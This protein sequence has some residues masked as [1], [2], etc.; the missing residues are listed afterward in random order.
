[1]HANNGDQGAIERCLTHEQARDGE[2]NGPSSPERAPLRLPVSMPVSQARA[3]LVRAD[4]AIALV[5]NRG[6]DVGVVTAED[7]VP[8]RSPLPRSISDVMG[9]EVVCV[10]PTTDLR[11]TLRTYREAAWSSAIRRRPGELPAGWIR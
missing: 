8:D 9:R 7:L 5:T 4:E 6:V 11:R 10:D 3:A 1:M 2:S